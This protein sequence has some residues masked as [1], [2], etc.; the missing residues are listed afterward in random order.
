MVSQAK[1]MVAARGD[2]IVRAAFA[3][4]DITAL[5]VAA[6]VVGG[7]LLFCATA[8]LLMRGAPPGMHIGPHLGLL[9]NY[10][11]GYSVSWPGSVIGL[12]YGAA[13]GAAIGALFGILWNMVHYVYMLRL[14]GPAVR[15]SVDV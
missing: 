4:L 15:Q 3:R 13:G 7:F 12:V 14:G 6:G 9:A 1:E 10:L 5:A 11:P 2:L 8:W